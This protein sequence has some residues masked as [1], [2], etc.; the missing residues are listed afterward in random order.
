MFT[1]GQNPYQAVYNHIARPRVECDNA[2]YV[3]VCGQNRYIAYA[4]DILQCDNLSPFAVQKVFAERN[5]RRAEAACSRI[6]HAKIGHR[7]AARAFGNDRAFSDL[8][9]AFYALAE[10]EP[11]LRRM[12]HRVSVRTDKVYRTDRYAGFFAHFKTRVR[13]Q[14]AQIKIK[15]AQFF[16]AARVS[17]R[18]SQKFLSYFFGII[19]C[20][21]SALFYR[22]FG[23]FGAF[24]RYAGRIRIF[25]AVFSFRGRAAYVE[26]YRVYAVNRGSAH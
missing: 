4:A 22:Q 6:A 1:A 15:H 2:V 25:T 24:V 18:Q 11:F 26:Q 12:E 3:F 23:K 16:A 17:G 14:F 5:Q 8:Q 10:H 9:R 21:E 13:K 7:N 20:N 19:K